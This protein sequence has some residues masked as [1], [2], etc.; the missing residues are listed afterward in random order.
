MWFL[1]ALI[2]LL[3][4]SGSDLFSKIGC[5]N[6]YEKHAAL[7]MVVAVGFIM[8]LHAA[9]ELIFNG[10]VFSLEVVWI[11]LPVSALYIVSMAIGY[12][13]LKYIELSISSPICNTS[14][15]LMVVFHMLRGVMPETSVLIGIAFTFLGVIGIGIAEY[16]EDEV[17]RAERQK[18]ANHKYVKSFLAILLPIVYALIDAWGTYADSR[19]LELHKL[20]EAQ[21]NVAYELTFFSVGLLIFFYLLIR[22]EFKATKTDGAKLSAAIFET[23]GQFAYIYALGANAIAA[24]PIISCYC[25]LTV[26]WSRIF[27]KEKLSLKHYLSILL[28]LIGIVILAIFD[29]SE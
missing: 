23:A 12:F 24:A 17:T 6:R 27:L 22:G 13:G 29:P 8:G 1:F 15:A 5:Q 26:V 14:G 2:A 28:A 25:V 20:D 16:T 4:W 21:A 7:K 19:V 18:S 3:M 9:Y 10:V 11:Y